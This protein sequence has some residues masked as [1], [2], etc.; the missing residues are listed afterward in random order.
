VTV[1][2]THA[3]GAAAFTGMA[4][5]DNIG[6]MAG[7][8][9]NPA[10]ETNTC[11]GGTAANPGSLRYHY[12]GSLGVGATSC[13]F[14]VDVQAPAGTAPR[15]QRRCGQPD[16]RPGGSRTTAA[17]ATDPVHQRRSWDEQSFKI[18]SACRV[19]RCRADDL[20]GQQQRGALALT[21]AALTDTFQPA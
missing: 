4:L 1:V 8:D 13:T 17:T 12:Q 19:V 6:A 20:A 2:I 5:T 21:Q 18:R 15:H 9:R 7:H 14:A 16:D 11:G 10:D 3:N